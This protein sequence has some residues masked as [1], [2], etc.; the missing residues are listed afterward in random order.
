[1]FR[2]IAERA[3]R[4]TLI[5]TPT[6]LSRSGRRYSQTGARARRCSIASLS[7]AHYR[8]GDRLISLSGE[9]WKRAKQGFVIIGPGKIPKGG[10]RDLPEFSS[11][12]ITIAAYLKS[13][14]VAKSLQN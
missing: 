11:E 8:D 12:P 6:C 9:R 10:L 5:I 7:G 3:E 1:M 2:V 14:S 4:A 13:H